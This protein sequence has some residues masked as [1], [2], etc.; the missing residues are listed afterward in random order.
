MKLLSDEELRKAW[1]REENREQTE[2]QGTGIILTVNY[3][4]ADISKQDTWTRKAQAQLTREEALKEAGEWIRE[5]CY[6][7]KHDGWTMP[8]RYC[9][10][11]S[12]L[13]KQGKLEE[14]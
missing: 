13:L 1:Q 12:N 5:I 3:E 10:V 14:V 8:R 11:C 4:N 6:E 2:I 7:P 9:D